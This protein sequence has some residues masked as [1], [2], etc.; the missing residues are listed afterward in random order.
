MDFREHVLATFEREISEIRRYWVWILILSIVLFGF[1][2]ITIQI[3]FTFYLSW[4][5]VAIWA[6]LGFINI[7]IACVIFE[8]LFWPWYLTNV[9]PNDPRINCTYEEYCGQHAEEH[10]TESQELCPICNGADE[11]CIVRPSTPKADLSRPSPIKEDLDEEEDILVLPKPDIDVGLASTP[12]RS[13]LVV[14]TPK[15]TRP[16]PDERLLLETPVFHSRST[17]RATTPSREL[18][19]TP[20]AT[21]SRKIHTRRSHMDNRTPQNVKFSEETVRSVSCTLSLKSETQ[22]LQEEKLLRSL[23]TPTRVEIPRRTPRQSPLDVNLVGEIE[24]LAEVTA[25]KAEIAKVERARKIA[26]NPRA[27]EHPKVNLATLRK[28]EPQEIARNPVQGTIQNLVPA[29]VPNHVLGIIRGILQL[30]KKGR[31]DR[32]QL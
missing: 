13:N 21:P 9:D 2:V 6:L 19:T 10:T 5:A 12:I 8:N 18:D 23:A 25:A 30:M 29:I 20:V 11:D 27:L 24:D 4:L 7:G 1:F 26:E 28:A 14:K 22:S 31:R 32:Q 16:E 3:A 15:S 17:T